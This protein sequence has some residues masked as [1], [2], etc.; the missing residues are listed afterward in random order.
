MHVYFS[1]FYAYFRET[2]IKKHCLTES[3]PSFCDFSVISS[4]YQGSVG[5]EY[6]YEKKEKIALKEKLPQNVHTDYRKRKK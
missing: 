3:D 2:N 6:K 1:L 5:L 4:D